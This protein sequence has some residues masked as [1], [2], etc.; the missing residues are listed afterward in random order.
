MI[1]FSEPVELDLNRN[2]K[3]S[4]QTP[5]RMICECKDLSQ[6]VD[7]RLVEASID[8]DYVFVS[9][10]DLSLKIEFMGQRSHTADGVNT[11][12]LQIGALVSNQLDVTHGRLRKPERFELFSDASLTILRN[13]STSDNIVCEGIALYCI[14][15][16][17]TQLT[18]VSPGK[19]EN[20]KQQ[21]CQLYN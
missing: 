2:C 8:Y 16:S 3:N 4:S 14:S 9:C 7:L 5:N 13:F 18:F 12:K 6:K 15:E 21:V 11:H 19:I 20:R 17:T 10:Q 1:H